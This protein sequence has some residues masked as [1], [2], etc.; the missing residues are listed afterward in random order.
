V[1]L[2]ERD[3]SIQRRHQKVVE[4]APSAVLSHELRKEMGE[5]ALRIAEA[6]NYR[7]AGTVEFLL[8]ENNNFYFL[9]MNTRLQ[10]EHPVSEMITGLDLVR[11]QIEVARGK[12]LSFKQSDLKIQGHAI[13]VRVYAEDPANNFLPDIGTLHQYK[14][15][16]G[17]GIRVDDAYEEGM[18]IPIYYDPMIAKLIAWGTDREDARKKL[19]RAIDDYKISGVATTLP[20]CRFALNHPA[21]IDG[22][23]DTRFVGL[24][25]TPDKLENPLHENEALAVAAV[26]PVVYELLTKNKGS[27]GS[28]EGNGPKLSDSQWKAKRKNYR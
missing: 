8:D 14:I 26:M 17:N 11:E 23:F 13:E 10:V 24:Y 19:L 1:Y 16:R 22:K 18:D 12:K 15:P 21:F 25:F 4:E 27:N 9:E 3:C 7:G 28:G 6:C 20:F 5:C 2:F